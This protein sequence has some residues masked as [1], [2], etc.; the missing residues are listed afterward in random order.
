V[1]ETYAVISA[2][3]EEGCDIRLACDTLGVTR[4]GYY[5]FQQAPPSV[6]DQEDDRLGAL[7]KETFWFHRRRFGARRI[8]RDLAARGERCGR[9]RT[10]KIMD[11]MSLAA[12]QPR[13]FKPRTTESRHTLGY[14]DNLLLTEPA[15]R[16]INQIWVGDI[17]YVPLPRSYA[18]LAI[19]MDLH[20][21]KIVGWTLRDDMTETL[22][23]TTLRKSIR[24]RQPAP[25]LIHHTDRG[26]QYAGKEYRELLA[27]AA[28][29]QSMSRPDNCYDNAFMESCFGKL[30]TEMEITCFDNLQKAERE[31]ADF[32]NYYNQL[33]RHSA[34]DYL[35]PNQYELQL[36]TS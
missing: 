13:S 25:G 21:R 5:R 15:P 7:V 30:K 24:L 28:M 35:T 12:I 3:E 16:G 9:K 32:I 27:R 22:V 11:Q 18:Y 20:S 23:L 26:G 31:I 8:A 34:L 17:T 2:L 19:L 14:N 33:R 1:T 36:Q 6:R 29:R 10:R 4:S